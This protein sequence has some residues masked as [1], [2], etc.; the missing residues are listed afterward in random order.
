MLEPAERNSWIVCESSARE[1]A[2][3]QVTERQPN[4]TAIY[5]QHARLWQW[6]AWV[7]LINT[8]SMTCVLENVMTKEAKEEGVVSRK[9]DAFIIGFRWWQWR[10][11]RNDANSGPVWCKFRAG[12][13]KIQG[14]YDANSGPVWCKFRA[15]TMQIQGRYD[16]NLGPVWSDSVSATWSFVCWLLTLTRDIII[17]VDWFCFITS[18]LRMFFF[19]VWT[20]RRREERLGGKG[21]HSDRWV[22]LCCYLVSCWSCTDSLR[23]HVRSPNH[24]Y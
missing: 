22:F 16:A 15:G 10:R 17:V 23:M 2:E 13:M 1:P 12:T 11:K 6:P 14:R 18:Y 7:T 19:S 24:Q 4:Q 5:F 20:P 8:S 9:F 21:Q 3:K